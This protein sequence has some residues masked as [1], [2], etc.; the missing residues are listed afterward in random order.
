MLD[1]ELVQHVKDIFLNPSVNSNYSKIEWKKVDYDKLEELLVEKHNFS[2]NRIDSALKKLK[3]IDS[4]KKQ[5]SLD[6]FFK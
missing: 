6:S 3:D 2:K 4:A 5:I 1:M